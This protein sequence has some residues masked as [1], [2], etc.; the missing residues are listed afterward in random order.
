MAAAFDLQAQIS[1]LTKCP[2]CL[3]D[4]SNPKSLP[5]L[6]TFCLRCLESH[7]R[8]AVPGVEFRCP[9]C[10]DTCRIPESGI[11]AFPLNFFV[12]EL[13]CARKA[14]QVDKD[15]GFS[16]EACSEAWEGEAVDIPPAAKYCVDCSQ[17]V[18][19]KCSRYHARKKTGAHL[20]VALGEEMSSELMQLRKRCC[21]EHR[22]ETVKLYCYD[23]KINMCSLCTA[24]GHKQHDVAEI[25]DAVNKLVPD[26]DTHVTAVSDGFAKIDGLRQLWDSRHREFLAE[27]E[28]LKATVKQEGEERKKLIE[29]NVDKLLEE[30]ESRKLSYAK[31]VE[32]TKDRL[33]DTGVAMQ[34]YINYSHTIRTKGSPSDITHAADELCTRATTL[35]Q[36][37][38]LLKSVES[39]DIE[40]QPADDNLSS[41]NL[42]GR[43]KSERHTGINLQ[44][45][46]FFRLQSLSFLNLL[47]L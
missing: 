23:C 34:S 22:D 45:Q 15:E 17:R 19:E 43:W 11:S 10:R 33:E 12:N 21:L 35:L 46:C 37:D 47:W 28:K 9:I 30:L 32:V 27:T 1:D 6:H 29:A 24:L 3:E 5:C 2:I 20:V 38:V 44:L 26:L 39:L 42:V 13:L 36:T 25:G 40:F 31:E 18:C 7:C 16:C 14:A 4:Y 8:D 41:V